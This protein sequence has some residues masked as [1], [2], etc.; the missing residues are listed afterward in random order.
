MQRFGVKFYERTWDICLLLKQLSWSSDGSTWSS[1]ACHFS[2]AAIPCI[3]VEGALGWMEST[4]AL[5]EV[6]ELRWER[7]PAPNAQ[8][9]FAGGVWHLQPTGLSPAPAGTR[10]TRHLGCQDFWP[11]GWLGLMAS[12]VDPGHRG[13]TRL[14]AAP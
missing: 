14:A 6:L 13:V 1:W 3:T 10:T 12:P 2:Q 5:F 8:S 11:C 4:S 9:K 7:P